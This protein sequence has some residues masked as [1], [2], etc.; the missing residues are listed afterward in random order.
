MARSRAACFS[1]PQNEKGG[2]R[3]HRQSQPRS[4]GGERDRRNLDENGRR[5]REE[6][7]RRPSSSRLSREEVGQPDQGED[8]A[9][10]GRRT[11]LP[12]FTSPAPGRRRGRRI[13]VDPSGPIS[14]AASGRR[15]RRMFRRPGR[16]RPAEKLTCRRPL[17]VRSHRSRSGAGRGRAVRGRSAPTVP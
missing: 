9:V 1:I 14:A 11:P 4:Q 16:R 12:H 13:V 3:R 17:P 8:A 6:E 2:A 10:A 15:S 7:G 5:L